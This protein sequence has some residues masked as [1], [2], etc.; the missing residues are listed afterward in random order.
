MPFLYR[1]KYLSAA[2]CLMLTGIALA[3]ETP[4][5]EMSGHVALRYD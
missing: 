3:A 4:V 2:V 1:K 5:N